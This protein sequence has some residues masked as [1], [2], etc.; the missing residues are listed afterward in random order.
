MAEVNDWNA[1]VIEEYRANGGR[2]GGQ[3]EGA[4]LLL[5]T[6]TGAKSGRERVTPLAYLLEDGALYVFASKAGHP[7]NPD[8][9]HNLVA[10]P[11][12]TVELGSEKFRATAKVIDGAERDRIFARQAEANPVFAQYQEKTSRAIPVVALERA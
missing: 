4:S 8:W 1:R 7:R 10:N 11:E 3:F 5:L 9:F 6:T 2:L 12:V